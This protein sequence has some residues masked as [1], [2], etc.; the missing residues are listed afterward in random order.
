MPTIWQGKLKI[1]YNKPAQLNQFR[2]VF[3]WYV[4]EKPL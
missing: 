4:K 3:N 2:P 1:R